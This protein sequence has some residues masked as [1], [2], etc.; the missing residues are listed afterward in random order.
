MK[1]NQTENILPCVFKNQYKKQRK[2]TARQET[3]RLFMNSAV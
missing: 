2:T 3:L 1:Q